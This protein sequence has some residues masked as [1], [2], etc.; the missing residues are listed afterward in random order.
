MN[1]SIR[2][3][4]CL[5]VLVLSAARLHAQPAPG[6]PQF[7]SFAGGPD[8][9]DLGNLNTHITIPIINKA[10]R[11]TNFTYDLSYDNSIWYPVTSGS[12]TT[13]QPVTNW[14]W[15]AQT[16]VAVG[17]ISYQQSLFQPPGCTQIETVFT[18]FAYHDEFG[19]T[20]GFGGIMLSNHG[21][22]WATSGSLVAVDGSGLTMSASDATGTLTASL[23]T[24]YGQNIY[25][26]LQVG[27]GSAT[28]TDRNGNQITV[29][30]SGHFY[31]TL[32][33]STPVLT[34]TG[35]GTPTNPVKLTYTAPSGG[36]PYY[37]VNYT[38][39]TVATNFGN[40]TIGEYKSSAA[41]P[42]VTSIDLP[43]G[44]QYTI[45]YETTPTTPTAGQCTAYPN[46]TCVTG[47]IASITYPTLGTISYLYYNANNN[48][49]ACT[50]GNNGVFSDG[51]ASCLLRTTPDG[52]WTYTRTQG[53]GAASTTTIA[54]PKLSYDSAANQT[55]IQFQG[56]Y[57]T[58]RV[59]NQGAS[60]ALQ[61][62]NT[63]YNGAA[64]PCTSTAITLPI[65]QR[66]VV[67]QYGSSGVQCKHTYFYDSYN[68]LKE[69]DDYDYGSGAPGALMRKE[70]VSYASLGNNLK[71][72]RQ[73]LTVCNGTGSSSACT[74]QSGSSTGTVVAQT[75]YNYDEGT[76]APSSGVVQ[77]TS[78]S[79]SR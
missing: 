67:D 76:P 46:T 70:I 40:S 61:T 11:G 64:S 15:R 9:I 38:N 35:L 7:G 5:F 54:A 8:V 24:K 75:N 50:T 73:T 30:S 2:V 10:G 3:L 74:G 26:P 31:D 27:T 16:E 12:T 33:S 29:D 34:A 65:T 39:F 68:N 52:A 17:Y 58:N 57:E 22:F 55:V 47:R 45:T 59:T 20:H 43:D 13:W 56:I 77:H 36:S 79:G 69:R 48:F 32:S 41:V 53:T 71:A 72:F 14:G 78:I 42:L 63:C 66:A 62:T 49:T 1:R 21:C 51:S 4:A 23:V 18:N 6:T 37:Q 60:S 28:A 44:S 25:P 19:I